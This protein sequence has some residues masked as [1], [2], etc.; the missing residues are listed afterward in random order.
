[1]K[2]IRIQIKLKMFSNKNIE[3]CSIHV[4]NSN[5]NLFFINELILVKRIF[6]SI[7]NSQI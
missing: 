4:P 6:G 2:K 7:D 5:P 3:K 1:M